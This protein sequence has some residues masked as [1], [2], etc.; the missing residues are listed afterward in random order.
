MTGSIKW[1][2]ALEEMVLDLKST[3]VSLSTQLQQVDRGLHTLAFVRSSQSRRRQA[4]E[5]VAGET[6]SVNLPSFADVKAIASSLSAE[7]DHR[8]CEHYPKLYLIRYLSLLPLLSCAT[9]MSFISYRQIVTGQELLVD[10]EEPTPNEV[11]GFEQL[12]M[13]Y[14]E[15]FREKRPERKRSHQQ[16]VAPATS[17]HRQLETARDELLHYLRYAWYKLPLTRAA[18]YGK[19]RSYCTTDDALY[20]DIVKAIAEGV[21]KALF[22][23]AKYLP[24]S[25]SGHT[26]LPAPQGKK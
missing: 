10:G 14:A 20:T 4:I 9:L 17:S 24:L 12:A 18:Y 21:V 11:R 13:G 22:N 16:Q 6:T 23:D 5:E 26:A 25:T 8:L 7:A 15:S 2:K 3:Q 19:E 1:T